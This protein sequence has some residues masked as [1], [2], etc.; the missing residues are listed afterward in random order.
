MNPLG[1]AF[2][3]F[4]DF[5]RFRT[6]EPLENPENLIAKAKGKY[7]V[8]TYKTKPVNTVGLSPRHRRSRSSMAR[9]RTPST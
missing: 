4:D 3:K 8:D 5:G 6:E 2:E 7:N 9:S 1:Y